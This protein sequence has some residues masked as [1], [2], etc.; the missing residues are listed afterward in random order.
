MANTG[1]TPR[2]RP[3]VPDPRTEQALASVA[4]SS[5][6]KGHSVYGFDFQGG[7]DIQDTLKGG[8][9]GRAMKLVRE[10]ELS[11]KPTFLELLDAG[12]DGKD[13]TRAARTAAIDVGLVFKKG[14]TV[15]RED[16]VKVI[17]GTEEGLATGQNIEEL[18]QLAI[19]GSRKAIETMNQLL[20]PERN[21]LIS[22]ALSTMEQGLSLASGNLT[23]G[24]A[25]GVLRSANELFGSQLSGRGIGGSGEAA[26][27][28][29]VHA[30]DALQNFGLNELSAGAGVLDTTINTAGNLGS[31]A[32]G[33]LN[34]GFAADPFKDPAFN[35]ARADTRFQRE[36]GF[37]LFSAQQNS[38]HRARQLLNVEN[39]FKQGTV[40]HI[41]EGGL[42]G[43]AVQS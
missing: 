20:D 19:E 2:K 41:T 17:E 26:F 1:A 32:S 35:V 10:G 15:S 34:T 43:D 6:L 12:F 24:P 5:G 23:S 38:L 11:E 27:Q 40:R 9:R 42:I 7:L 22:N 39:Q 25:Q 29:A 33:Q 28:G 31:I 36:L 30:L 4:A 14:R 8:S 3:D 13:F 16:A 37:H 21:P 18:S